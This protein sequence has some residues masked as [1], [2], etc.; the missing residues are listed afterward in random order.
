MISFHR[1][2]SSRFGKRIHISER[3]PTTKSVL[4]WRF[5]AGKGWDDDDDDRGV[6]GYGALFPN[7]AVLTQLF[8]LSVIYHRK[9]DDVSRHLK[10]LRAQTLGHGGHVHHHACC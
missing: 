10:A 9:A 8:R 7:L 4:R 5:R 6:Y 1:R 2:L 3:R